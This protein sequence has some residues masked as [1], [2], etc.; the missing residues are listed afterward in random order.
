MDTIDKIE[1][2][3]RNIAINDFYLMVRR[4]GP[5]SKEYENHLE[6]VTSE[7]R[8]EREKLL[9]EYTPSIVRRNLLREYS[10]VPYCGNIDCMKSPRTIF[11][12]GQFKCHTCGW[13]SSFPKEFIS[14][15]KQVHGS[16]NI[17]KE[18]SV[19]Y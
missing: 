12:D 2:V 16:V 8:K 11:T 13:E 4:E 1:E 3:N 17:S 18:I 19:R 15:W 9:A 14:A 7:L 5:I 6:K 10:Y